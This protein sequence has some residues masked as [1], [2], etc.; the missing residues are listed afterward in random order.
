MIQP[1]AHVTVNHV[2]SSAYRR[3][4]AGGMTLE[5]CQQRARRAGDQFRKFGRVNKN[6]VGKFASQPRGRGRGRA[7]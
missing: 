5:A 4:Q 2:Y 6:Y 1:P 3:A 7:G